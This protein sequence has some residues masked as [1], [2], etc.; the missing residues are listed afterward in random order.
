M[1]HFAKVAMPKFLYQLLC[2]M[3]VLLLMLY[4]TSADPTACFKVT[5]KPDNNKYF[6]LREE[7]PALL[8]ED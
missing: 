8:E 4:S 6:R 7:N 5:V 2:C 3:Y 1:Q